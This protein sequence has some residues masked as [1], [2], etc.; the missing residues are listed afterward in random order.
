MVAHAMDLGII[1]FADLPAGRT[2]A[3][4]M[5]QLLEE[6]ELAEQVG[7]DVFGVGEHHRPDYPPRRRPSR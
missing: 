6:A 2:G 1:T 4:R 3:E 7:L 5:R